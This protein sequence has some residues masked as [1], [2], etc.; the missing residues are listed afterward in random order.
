MV[1]DLQN[2]VRTGS[3]FD[4]EIEEAARNV[5]NNYFEILALTIRQALGAV[6]LAISKT[7]N[8]WDTDNPMLLVK[9]ARFV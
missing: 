6:E 9:G 7:D 3:L 5:S 2:A 4:N 8:G 1:G